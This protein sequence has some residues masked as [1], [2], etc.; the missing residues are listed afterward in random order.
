MAKWRDQGGTREAVQWLHRIGDP[1]PIHHRNLP[2]RASGS[3][4]TSLR[5]CQQAPSPSVSLELCSVYYYHLGGAFLVIW[6]LAHL[7][8]SLGVPN[9]TPLHMPTKETKRVCRLSPE[10]R[11]APVGRSS[12][13]VRNKPVNAPLPLGFHKFEHSARDGGVANIDPLFFCLPQFV[14]VG[15]LMLDFPVMDWMPPRPFCAVLLSCELPPG[16]IHYAQLQLQERGKFSQSTHAPSGIEPRVAVQV[17]DKESPLRIRCMHHTLPGLSSAILHLPRSTRVQ[18][19]DA[20]SYQ[21]DLRAAT[22]AAGAKACSDS[23]RVA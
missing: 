23:E 20:G 1:A 14:C 4:P 13:S 15:Y 2:R 17:H 6:T 18:I 9:T 7:P 22:G 3:L 21:R 19:E 12:P 5:H 11:V 16:Y 10:S 8:H